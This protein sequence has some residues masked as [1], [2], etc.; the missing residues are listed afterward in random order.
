MISKMLWQ[1]GYPQ[2]FSALR[3][4]RKKR[5]LPDLH[6]D[7]YGSGADRRAIMYALSLGLLGEGG[8]AC[9]TNAPSPPQGCLPGVHEG[10]AFTTRPLLSGW[11]ILYRGGGGAGGW[12]RGQ[13][14]VCVPKIDLQVRAPLINFIF[15]RRKNFL[16]WV[17]GWVGQPK[18][19]GANLTPPPPQYH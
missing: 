10:A 8:C 17:G 6:I 15:F 11:L 7:V 19:R 1:K 12:V 13:K 16:M 18:S 14:K 3:Y 2:L 4:L 9:H 5:L